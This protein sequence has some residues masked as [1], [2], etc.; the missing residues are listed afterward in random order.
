MIINRIRALLLP[1]ILLFFSF[2]GA[3]VGDVSLELSGGY[4]YRVEGSMKYIMADHI[5]KDN[6]YPEVIKYSYNKDFILAVQKPNRDRGVTFLSNELSSMYQILVNV[7]EN[8]RS[9]I[10][11]RY[12]SHNSTI[13]S[14]QSLF[15][16]LKNNLSVNNSIEDIKQGH[17]ISDSVLNNDPYYQKVFSNDVNYWIIEHRDTKGDN[18]SSVLHG[19]LSEQEYNGM[20]EHLG[21]PDDLVL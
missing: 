6:I 10:I 20:R 18:T 4:T 9:S 13:I 16:T 11:D 19:P 12:D 17:V 7:D 8:E 21:I 3:G 5:F 1:I 2:C 14:E 15:N